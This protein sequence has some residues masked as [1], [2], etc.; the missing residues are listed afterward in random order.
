MNN[1]DFPYHEL[2]TNLYKNLECSI[3]F[4]SVNKQT[5]IDGVLQIAFEGIKPWTF[6]YIIINK[7]TERR[8]E[9]QDMMNRKGEKGPGR[10]KRD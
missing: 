2:K 3:V 1:N 7:N 5:N 9:E 4:K 6:Q 10:K 8:H